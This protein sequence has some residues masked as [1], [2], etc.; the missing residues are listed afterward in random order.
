MKESSSVV[1]N[2]VE[3]MIDGIAIVRVLCVHLIVQLMT[4]LLAHQSLIGT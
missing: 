3:M 2:N 4:L 1:A